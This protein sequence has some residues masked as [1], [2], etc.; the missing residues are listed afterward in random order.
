MGFLTPV[1][2]RL[3]VSLGM[4]LFTSGLLGGML[5]RP[6][7]A[8][9][10][11]AMPDP[12]LLQILQDWET[13]ASKIRRIDC[14][15]KRIVYDETFETEKRAIGELSLESPKSAKYALRPAAISNGE[16]SRKKNSRGEPFKVIDDVA[17]HWHWT[18]AQV[19]KINEASRTY[20]SISLPLE[21]L[22]ESSGRFWSQYQNATAAWCNEFWLARPFLLGLPTEE[23]LRR[24][25][26]TLGQQTETE[27]WLDLEPRWSMDKMNYQKARLILDRKLMVP[28]AIQVVDPTGNKTTVHVILNMRINA[29]RPPK[30]D[31]GEP[32]LEGYRRLLLLSS[33]GKAGT[34]EID[35]SASLLCMAIAALLWVLIAP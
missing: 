17:E 5:Q 25:K 15:F 3:I 22:A 11:V 28:K 32:N 14:A 9:L 35:F 34:T 2:D 4:C 10:R 29:P 7:A 27:L 24:F 20:E 6:A 30:D 21:P 33:D 19:I 16:V 1:V 31:L 23:M 12:A 26:I 13:A 8:Q 18:G